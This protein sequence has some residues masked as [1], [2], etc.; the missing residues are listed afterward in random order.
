MA[1][2]G[3]KESE[4]VSHEQLVDIR[5][6]LREGQLNDDDVKVI[7]RLV[8][9]VEAASKALRAAMVE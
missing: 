3:G 5:K 8:T 4:R 7:E 2:Y 6:R 1:D 9:D